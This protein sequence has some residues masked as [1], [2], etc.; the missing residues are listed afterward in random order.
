MNHCTLKKEV[1]RGL[2]NAVLSTLTLMKKYF[3]RCKSIV[4][5][6]RCSRRIWRICQKVISQNG[7]NIFLHKNVS[8]KHHETI[9]K[10]FSCSVFAHTELKR[11]R[12][13]REDA[14]GCSVHSLHRYDVT[15]FFSCCRHK[16]VYD[17]WMGIK[18]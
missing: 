7:V 15:K 5:F 1:S 10:Y 16:T 17:S 3:T 4:L 2:F 18:V 6:L 11:M 12:V 8:R 14:T 9:R 13:F